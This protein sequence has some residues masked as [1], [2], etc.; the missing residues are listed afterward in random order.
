MRKY[1]TQV[2]KNA[3]N[4]KTYFCHHLADLYVH[5]SDLYVDFSLIH[6]LKNK[7]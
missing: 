5:L 6:L 4:F 1:S 2:N 7:I 3:V